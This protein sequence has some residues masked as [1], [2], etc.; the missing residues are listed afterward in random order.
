MKRTQ[1][2]SEWQRRLGKEFRVQAV[3]QPSA[4][5]SEPAWFEIQRKKNRGLRIGLML[6]KVWLPRIN[7]QH[8]LV[9]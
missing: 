9:R 6:V 4:E 1:S 3:R 5:V 2:M 8:V 7:Q